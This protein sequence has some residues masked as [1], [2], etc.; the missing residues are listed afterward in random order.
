MIKLAGAKL[1]YEMRPGDKL[2]V[3]NGSVIIVNPEHKPLMVSSIGV[4][5]L[6]AWT[7]TVRTGTMKPTILARRHRG[8]LSEAMKTVKEI[9]PTIAAVR[10]FFNEPDGA[11]K[12]EPY[13]FDSRI[14]WNTHIVTVNGNAVGFTDGPVKE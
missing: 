12:V 6:D 11:I 8:F 14:G 10:E 2:M 3:L 13:G 1:V 5:D 7:P 9:E 4:M